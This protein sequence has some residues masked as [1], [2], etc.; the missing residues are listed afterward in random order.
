MGIFYKLLN[1]S[2]ITGILIQGFT[3][4]PHLDYEQTILYEFGFTN[5]FNENLSF[6]VKAYNKDISDQTQTLRLYANLG[7]PV[8]LYDNRGFARARGLEFELNKKPGG[9]LKLI[10]GSITY[11]A[12][13]ATGYSSSTFGNMYG[14]SM[15]FQ[16][17]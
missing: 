11:T 12:Q 1:F 8:W 9:F 13:W 6:D 3:G 15:G 5:Q 10:S 2:I 7:L 17:L 4:N 14:N 16:T